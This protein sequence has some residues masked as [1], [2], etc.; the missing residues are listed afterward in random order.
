MLAQRR[1]TGEGRKARDRGTGRPF[2]FAQLHSYVDP[3]KD[4]DI[5]EAARR[6]ALLGDPTRLRIPRVLMERTEAPVHEVAALAGTSRFNA[7]AHLGR[8][9]VC[10]LVGRRREASTVYYRV[11]DANL[12]AICEAMGASL[13]VRS[14]AATSS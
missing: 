9:A 10:G 6:F 4:A 5:E 12:P 3:M 14:V 13:R 7:S 11:I 2:V 8:L 1:R